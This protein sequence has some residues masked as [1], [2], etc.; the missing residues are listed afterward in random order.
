MAGRLLDIFHCLRQPGSPVRRTISQRDLLKLCQRL[1]LRGFCLEGMQ[2]AQHAFQDTMD[3]L[4]QSIRDPATR[5]A[6]AQQCGA[7]LGLNKS[8]ALF[9][10]T[11]NKPEIKETASS[12]TVGRVVLPRR[13]AQT[14]DPLSTAT[15]RSTFAGTRHALVLTEQLAAAVASEEPVLLVGETGVGKTAAVQHLAE[16]TVKKA[17][18]KLAG[19]I[20]IS[21]YEKVRSPPLDREDGHPLVVLNMSQQSDSSDLLG[22]FKPVDIKLL[23]SPVR[24]AFEALFSATF[25]QTQNAKFLS[26]ITTCF[27]GRR[28]R[29]LFNLMSHTQKSAVSK[30]SKPGCDKDQLERW[31]ALGEQLRKAEAQARQAENKLTFAFVEGA[32]VRALK[33]GSWVLL[34]EINLAEGEALESLAPVLDGSSPVL[35]ERGDQKPLKRHPEFRLFACMNPATDVGKKDLPAGIRSRFTEVYLEEPLEEGDLEL[36]V[37]AYL[38]SSGSPPVHACVSLYLNLRKAAREPD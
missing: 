4:C 19:S 20:R 22:G 23:L 29:D 5:Q 33:E 12:V 2:A 3:C 38:G 9:F 17:T 8:E 27:A 1:V 34:D 11:M 6:L 13:K 25:S 30:L 32:L 37:A 26:H 21:L 35:F 10:C 7:L 28:W 36:V 18:P 16:I 14:R 15:K 31:R 24:E